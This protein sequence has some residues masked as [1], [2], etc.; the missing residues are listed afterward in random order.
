MK[1]QFAEFGR[2]LPENCKRLGLNRNDLLFVEYVELAT[3][4]VDTAP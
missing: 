3:Q 2:K 4:W 1:H